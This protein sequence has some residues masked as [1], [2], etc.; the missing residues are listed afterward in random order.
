MAESARHQQTGKSLHTW[1]QHKL[2]VLREEE[3]GS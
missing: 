1:A 3:T 2:G